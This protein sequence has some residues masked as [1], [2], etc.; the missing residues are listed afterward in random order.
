MGNKAQFRVPDPRTKSPLVAVGTLKCTVN[1][2]IP[3]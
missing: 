1:A 2:N 3:Q